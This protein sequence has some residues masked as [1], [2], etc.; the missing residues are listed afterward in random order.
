[1]GYA[2]SWPAAAPPARNR[3]DPPRAPLIRPS[4]M[5]I[6]DLPAFEL[7]MAPGKGSYCPSDTTF[8]QCSPRDFDMSEES[9]DEEPAMFALSDDDEDGCNG[10]DEEKFGFANFQLAGFDDD[11]TGGFVTLQ[12]FPAASWDAQDT[13]QA[14]S[15][16]PAPPMGH[17]ADHSMKRPRSET[18]Q[19]QAPGASPVLLSVLEQ[20]AAS[21]RRH[22]Q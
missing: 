21:H 16:L 5:V 3:P 15:S 12:T 10:Q 20:V 9:D 2:S 18:L 8:D 4:N 22:T 19:T 6:K 7:P 14:S 17:M 11:D 13:M 1:M